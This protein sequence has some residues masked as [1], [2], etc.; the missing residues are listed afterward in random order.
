[1]LTESEVVSMVQNLQKWLYNK[2]GWEFHYLVLN[3]LDWSKSKIHMDRNQK[4]W[5]VVPIK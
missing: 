3:K 5:L 4:R 2:Q 1:M